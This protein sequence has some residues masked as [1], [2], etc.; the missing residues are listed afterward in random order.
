[1]SNHEILIPEEEVHLYMALRR[2]KDN[3]EGPTLCLKHVSL[4]PKTDVDVLKARASKEPGIWRIYRTVNPRSTSVAAK[5]LQKDLVDNPGHSDRIGFLWR[6]NLLKPEC[7]VGRG[8][9]IDIDTLNPYI[10]DQVQ[11]TVPDPTVIRTPNG[12][13]IV[14][15]KFDTRELRSFIRDNGLF[16]LIELKADAYYFVERFEIEE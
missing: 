12:Y 15:P 14:S 5:M 7:R 11:A 8:V 1:M 10:L 2:R 3:P 6:R 16:S 4:D 13:H 9:L